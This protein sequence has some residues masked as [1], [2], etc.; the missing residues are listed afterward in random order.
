MI[1]FILC[2]VPSFLSKTSKF[3]ISQSEVHIFI[4]TVSKS[5]FK[6]LIWSP[7]PTEIG[8]CNSLPN[9]LIHE[10]RRRPSV[11][12][13]RTSTSGVSLSLLVSIA[14]GIIM[15]PTSAEPPSFLKKTRKKTKHEK[16]RS[17]EHSST[18][19][20]FLEELAPRN[21]GSKTS[22]Q[23]KA[24]A[25]SEYWLRSALIIFILRSVSSA[26]GQTRASAGLEKL[27]G[28]GEG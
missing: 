28:G 23:K 2:T 17:V 4:R 22:S 27:P 7:S 3:F 20:S 1:L 12:S 25:G 13:K 5:C 19:W 18:S 8:S 26:S 6:S 11:F 24:P 21:S 14:D 9:R 15:V 10:S 16:K